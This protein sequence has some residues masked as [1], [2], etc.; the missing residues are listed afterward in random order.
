MSKELLKR[1]ESLTL[2]VE[3]LEK[4]MTKNRRSKD[5]PK[6]PSAL[7]AVLHQM[8]IDGECHRY[9]I[10]ESGVDVAHLSQPIHALRVNYKLGIQSYK[11][12]VRYKMISIYKLEDSSKDEAL[13]LLNYWRVKR[14]ESVLNV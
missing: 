9:S 6:K 12:R 10:R 2:R 4:G 1:I 8:L 14:G 11:D 5:K 13:K 7:E 3:A